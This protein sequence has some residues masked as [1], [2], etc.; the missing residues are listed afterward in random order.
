[1]EAGFPDLGPVLAGLRRGELD[2][3]AALI[4]THF[5]YE[6]KRLV[7]ALNELEVAAANED[8]LG[9]VPPD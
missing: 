7:G 1:M 6:E 5:T 9:V 8:L 2:T 4:E 3:L